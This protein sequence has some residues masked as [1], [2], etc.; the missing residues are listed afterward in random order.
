MQGGREGRSGDCG[1]INNHAWVQ[2]LFPSHYAPNESYFFSKIMIFINYG[3][4]FGH[5]FLC[6]G[7]GWSIGGVKN[8]F[9]NSFTLNSWRQ[10]CM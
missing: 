2:F 8:D 10:D 1:S 4:F 5:C 7:L 9:L 6:Y 3:K